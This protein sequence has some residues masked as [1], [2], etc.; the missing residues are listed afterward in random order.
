MQIDADAARSRQRVVL[1]VDSD[2]DSR[3]ACRMV[4]SEA[5]FEVITASDGAAALLVAAIT[6]PDVLL[7]DVDAPAVSSIV[8]TG[9]IRRHGQLGEVQIIAL[10]NEAH[11]ERRDLHA[12]RF[13]QVLLRP[14]E[15]QRIVEA[16]W[17]LV[18]A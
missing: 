15:P 6:S 14:P 2:E 13:D 11:S 3:R 17:A 8:L 18:P 5:G 16:V 10:T 12:T 4:L 7:L 1:L 9:D